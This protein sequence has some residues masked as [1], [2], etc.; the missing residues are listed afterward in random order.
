[1]IALV[2]ALGL[3]GS[4]LAASYYGSCTEDACYPFNA[5][6]SYV[7]QKAVN[8]HVPTLNST[9][10][11]KTG[12]SV[13]PRDVTTPQRTLEELQMQQRAAMLTGARCCT[14]RAA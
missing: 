5:T 10:L 11:T 12:D 2:L 13:P 1:M 3:F 14:A 4:A 6:N 7:L 8:L 9:H